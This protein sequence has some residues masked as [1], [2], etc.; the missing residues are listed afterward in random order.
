MK[1]CKKCGKQKPVAAFYPAAGTLDGLRGECKACSSATKKAW[2]RKNR[3]RAIA[4]AVA[5]QRANQDRYNARMRE[6]RRQHPE[7]ARADHLRRKFGLTLDEYER[8]LDRQGGG[9][10]ICG[11]PPSDRISLHIDHDHGTGD[12]RGLLCVRCNNAIGLLRENPDL[13]RRAIRYV[14]ADAPL[15][16]QRPE[17]ERLGRERALGLRQPAA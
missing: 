13:M 3:Q 8:M 9:C 15:R 14:S 11:S 10:H 1:R 12:I 4:R 16:S 2:Y 7:V 6:Y 17:L 5:W